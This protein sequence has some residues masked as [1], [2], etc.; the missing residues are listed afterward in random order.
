MPSP[1]DVREILEEAA[2]TLVFKNRRAAANKK[3]DSAQENLNRIDDIIT[4]LESRISSLKGQVETAE[5][6]KHLTEEH[7]SKELQV[8]KHNHNSLALKCKK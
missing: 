8:F 7:S 6:W 3:L 5:K 1:E 2:G 4:E